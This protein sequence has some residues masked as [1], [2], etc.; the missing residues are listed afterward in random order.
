MTRGMSKPDERQTGDHAGDHEQKRERKF[1]GEDEI[2]VFVQNQKIDDRDG[3]ER[4]R[5]K[6]QS[7][8]G[9]R[10]GFFSK[11][12]VD[13]ETETKNERDP[14]ETSVAKGEI[15]NASGRERD[16]DELP[17]GQPFAQKHRAEKDVD[18]R[19]HEITEAGF[20]NVPG[21]HGPDEEE[22]VNRDRNST[23]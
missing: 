2:A 15:K 21:V 1:L 3:H 17:A 4:H 13:S 12:T 18:E 6:K 9:A 23:R 5:F 8:N 20:D 10:A 7:R 11:Q 16:R 14:R 22:P 19:R